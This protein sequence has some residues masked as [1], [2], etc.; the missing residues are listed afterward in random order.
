MRT[1]GTKNQ[2][3]PTE[4][5]EKQ[6][7]D[8]T[9]VTQPAGDPPHTHTLWATL[10]GGKPRALCPSLYTLGYLGWGTCTTNRAPGRMPPTSPHPVGLQIPSTL[11]EGWVPAPRN[12]TQKNIS[13]RDSSTKPESTISTHGQHFPIVRHGRKDWQRLLQKPNNQKLTKITESEKE[14]KINELLS[15]KYENIWKPYNYSWEKWQKILH[16]RKKMIP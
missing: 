2:L 13:T 4:E 15:R 3:E 5:A 7:N 10:R 1:K 12:R 16:L 9:L 11:M 8:N 6:K 14:A